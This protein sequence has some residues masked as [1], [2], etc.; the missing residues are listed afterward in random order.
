MK[1]ILK[2][3]TTFQKFLLLFSFVAYTV[4]AFISNSVDGW[5]AWASCVTFAIYLVFNANSKYISFV[6]LIISYAIYIYFNVKELYWGELATSIV[7]IGVNFV[8]MLNWKKNTKEDGLLI[9][10]LKAKEIILSFLSTIAICVAIYFFLCTLNTE[11]I[12]LNSILAN[13]AFVVTPNHIIS[14]S[15]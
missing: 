3:F 10:K 11:L 6:W 5:V 9:N 1:D 13:T 12:I 8:A 14:N 15:C 7:A 2:N 4:C